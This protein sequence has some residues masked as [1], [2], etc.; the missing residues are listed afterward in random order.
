[1]ESAGIS[2]L[3]QSP[4]YSSARAGRIRPDK[5]AALSYCYELMGAWAQ[6]RDAWRDCMTTLPDP[7]DRGQ[8]AVRKAHERWSY[9]EERLA[10]SG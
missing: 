6:A 1:M 8:P 4:G 3:Y 7:E 10:K 9:L 2:A 5:V